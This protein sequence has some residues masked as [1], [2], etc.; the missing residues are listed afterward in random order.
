MKHANK[1][2]QQKNKRPKGV[3][4]IGLMAS[5][6]FTLMAFEWATFDVNYAID[7]VKE[8]S[9][10]NLEEILEV[11]PERPKPKQT[12][13]PP[14]VKNLDEIKLIDDKEPGPIDDPIDDP[15]KTDDFDDPI[16]EID[17]GDETGGNG[18][19]LPDVPF[20]VVEEM[21]SFP[22]GDVALY[23]YLGNNIHHTACSR[24]MGVSKKLYIQFVVEKDGSIT[25]VT[26]P[27]EVGCGLDEIAQK[28]VKKMPNWKAGKQRGKPV[29]VKY[30]LP[31]QFSLK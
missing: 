15:K 9:V 28:A 26:V 29:R 1:N 30:T 16:K 13:K 17:D 25:N 12:V 14:E 22:G 10:L 3:F 23:K 21:P 5:L 7:D 19:T 4:L 27:R 18:P 2:K 31:I 11:M 8:V 24:E 20:T 6:G